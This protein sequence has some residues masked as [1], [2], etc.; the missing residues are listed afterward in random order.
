MSYRIEFDNAANKA[1]RS[2]QKN[3]AKRIVDAIAALAGE[4]RPPTCKKLSGSKHD[5]YR[6]RVGDYRVIYTIDDGVL[7]V[8]VV[9]IGNR[10][11]VYRSMKGV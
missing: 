4:P 9:R 2:I 11:E 8:L 1:L 10:R 7:L 3:D 5:L 6:I